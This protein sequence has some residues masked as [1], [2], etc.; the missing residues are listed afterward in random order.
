PAP[1][2]RSLPQEVALE[3]L[4]T[5]VAGQ[6]VL[7]IS[8]DTLA[9]VGFDPSGVLLLGGPSGSGRST[10]VMTL[11]QSLLRWDSRVELIYLGNR[12]SVA[13]QSSRWEAGA[14]DPE[15]VAVLARETAARMADRTVKHRIAVFVES[16]P[17]FLG[18][19]ADAVI[20]AL[21]REAKRS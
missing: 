4:P 16:L 3:E 21:A 20:V 13:F 8:D 1:A 17:D 5:E 12:R 10:A 19:P 14:F 18:T 11:A 7:G 15:S 2:I 6:P 9:P